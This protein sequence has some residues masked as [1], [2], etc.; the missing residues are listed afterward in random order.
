MKLSIKINLKPSP[1]QHFHLKETLKLFNKTCNSISQTAFHNQTFGKWPIQ[2]LIYH[3][4]RKSSGIPA[5][6]LIRAIALVCGSYKAEKKKMH[7]FKETSAIPFDSRIRTFHKSESVSLRLW[8]QRVTIPISLGQYQAT[9]LNGIKLS[10]TG[11]SDLIYDKV[12]DRF[13]LVICYDQPEAPTIQ[14]NQVLGLDLGIKIL[15]ADSDGFLYTGSQV[16]QT[17]KRYATLR[18]GLQAKG[19]KSAKRH[20]KKLSGKEHR[21]CKDVNHCLSKK[22]VQKAK[23][24]G[25][26]LVLE[27]LKGIRERLGRRPLKQEPSVLGGSTPKREEKPRKHVRK[28]V[29]T[30]INSWSFSQLRLFIAYK[31]KI[32]GVRVYVVPAYYSSQTCNVCGHV[33]KS[34]RVSRDDFHCKSCGHAEHADTNAAKVISKRAPVNEPT[35]V[36]VRQQCHH[37]ANYKPTT[38]VVVS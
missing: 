10:D 16:E 18:A 29:R 13:Y 23:G 25:R 5:Q 22:I 30:L 4:L 27:E 34:N 28:S 3:D 26:S 14:S 8:N 15:A 1:E 31:A 21:F 7:W 36:A 11:E 38:S 17:R 35:V 33:S 37:N 19:S 24:T 20:L 6:L 9:K 2:K 32:A 12:Q